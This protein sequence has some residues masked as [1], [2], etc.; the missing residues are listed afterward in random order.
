[1]DSFRCRD[2]AVHLPIPIGNSQMGALGMSTAGGTPTLPDDHNKS[3]SR[4]I[5]G[6]RPANAGKTLSP[7]SRGPSA[8]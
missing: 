4:G 2:K 5:A 1:M 8:P 3:N 6:L 7:S